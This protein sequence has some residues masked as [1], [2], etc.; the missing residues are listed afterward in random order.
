MLRELLRADPESFRHCRSRILRVVAHCDEVRRNL[1]FD[2][3]EPGTG[4]LPDP[5]DLL[6][7]SIERGTGDARRPELAGG[8][9]EIDADDI[10]HAAGRPEHLGSTAADQDRRMRTLYRQRPT[11][12]S[13]RMDV[14]TVDLQLL[15]APVG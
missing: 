4:A 2:V 6:F 14:P 10:R 5:A 7:R 3:T 11:G 1:Q 8:V 15:T 13:V 9:V 12:K